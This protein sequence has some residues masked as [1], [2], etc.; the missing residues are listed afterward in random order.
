MASEDFSYYLQ[1]IPGAY[2]LIGADDGPDHQAPCHSPHY[3]FNDRLIEKVTT[4]FAQVVGA[5]LPK[6][7]DNIDTHNTDKND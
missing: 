3:D 7:Q 6:T 1:K 4:L 5:P 2:A